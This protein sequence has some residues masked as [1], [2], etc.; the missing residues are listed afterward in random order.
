[1]YQGVS[2]WES[3]RSACTAHSRADLEN[4]AGLVPVEHKSVFYG[5]D[6]HTTACY[7]A[8]VWDRTLHTTLM[9]QNP[10]A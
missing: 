2:E 8:A 7:G 3:V 4:L 10:P 6:L 9:D 1:M 5:L